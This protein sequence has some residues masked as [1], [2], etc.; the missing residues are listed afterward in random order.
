M[1]RTLNHARAL[2]ATSIVSTGCSAFPEDDGAGSGE[3]WPVTFT[4]PG[5]AG[6]SPPR[7]TTPRSRWDARRSP[8]AAMRSRPWLRW[9]RPSPVVYPHMT[10]LGG[11]G[12][13]LVREPSGRVRALMAAGRAGAHARRGRY[14]GYE[15]IPPRGAPAALPVAG[16]VAA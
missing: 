3:R 9:R 2:H 15:T 12:F 4:P 7:R 11:D 8:K 14:R 16:P 10:Q 5:I 13:W 6:A 1:L